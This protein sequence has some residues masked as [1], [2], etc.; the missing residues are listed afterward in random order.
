MT[1]LR[2]LVLALALL[3]PV[4]ALAQG[5]GC[6]GIAQPCGASTP[7][8]TEDTVYT[9]PVQAQAST[10]G[11]GGSLAYS[12]TQIVRFLADDHPTIS[13]P[14]WTVV[15][16]RSDGGREIPATPTDVDSLVSAVS[17]KGD[18]SGLAAGDWIVLRSAAS[19]ETAERFMMYLEQDQSD[20]AY[21]WM[22]PSDNFV[23]QGAGNQSPPTI[24]DGLPAAPGVAPASPVSFST[25]VDGGTMHVA[26]TAAAVGLWRDRTAA[27]NIDWLYVGQVTT[28]GGPAD[29][30]PFVISTN[31]GVVYTG[32]AGGVTFG[33]R[34]SYD[35]T[36]L[37]TVQYTDFYNAS[38]V[39]YLQNTTIG[40]D[41]ARFE[42][43][44]QWLQVSV[45]SNSALFRP[46]LVKAVAT[47]IATKDAI[48]ADGWTG[49]DPDYVCIR[50]VATA[51]SVCL[52]S[53]GVTAWP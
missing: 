51:G 40:P 38:A 11:Y 25:F 48:D 24:A 26:A 53:D 23:A 2:S 52:P 13:G 12:L 8:P 14:G 29:A 39:G 27:T 16:A 33:T 44:D 19:I 22:F 47:R 45:A 37:V 6:P 49:G 35:G 43:L 30:R 5:L 4:P 50:T 17:W 42:M 21:V 10:G 20:R 31:P 28:L 9:Y 36:A 15:E 3:L 46:R 34:L 7:A 1:A 18:G 41:A 32:I